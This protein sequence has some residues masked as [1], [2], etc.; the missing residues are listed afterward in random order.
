MIVGYQFPEVAEAEYDSNWLMVK[1]VVRHPDGDWS[2]VDPAL[3]TYEVRELADW[4]RVV[5]S[6]S[7]ETREMAFLEPCLSFRLRSGDKR[8]D[9]LEI[10]LAHEFRPPWAKD[11]DQS[12]AML[13]PLSEIDLSSAADALQHELEQYPQRAAR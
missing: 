1:I 8:T 13:F 2:A 4:L 9:E 11:I 6:G 5:G 12:A 7:R 10:D 3:L